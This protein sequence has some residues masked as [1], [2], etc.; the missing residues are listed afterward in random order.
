MQTVNNHIPN[1]N[2]YYDLICINPGFND[3][4]YVMQ[5]LQNRRR[6]MLIFEEDLERN[7]RFVF[8][9][10]FPFHLYEIPSLSH[11]FKILQ[12][13]IR[14]APHLF[15]PQKILYFNHTRTPKFAASLTDYLY[16]NAYQKKLDIIAP[17][18]IEQLAF[19][20]KGTTKGIYFQEYKL[21]VSRLFIELLKYYTSQGGTLKV[22]SPVKRDKNRISILASQKTITANNIL[23]GAV[24]KNIHYLVPLQMP[25][26]FAMVYRDSKWAF[27]FFDHHKNTLV[28]PLTLKQEN[29]SV[30]T[31][32]TFAQK[33]FQDKIE[34]V[35]VWENEEK[36]TLEQ[37]KKFAELVPQPLDCSYKKTGLNDIYERCLEKFDLAKQTGISFAEFKTI[38]HR[39]GEAVDEITE[40]AYALLNESRDPVKIW[41]HAEKKYQKKYEWGI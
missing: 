19:I 13:V 2:N 8:T 36:P 29:T 18:H 17:E 20:R 3:L 22:N 16:K 38:F 11:K 10:T 34:K 33:L 27:R 40:D 28:E 7:D 37:L 26:D 15:Q 21:N 6:V 41:N 1:K 5:E 14:M 12:Q 31:F 39:Y 24:V 30:Q 23:I 25:E 32:T 4:L 9:R 35:T